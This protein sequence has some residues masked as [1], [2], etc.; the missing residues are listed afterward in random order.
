MQLVNGEKRY[1]HVNEL[2]DANN[3]EI[4][5]PHRTLYVGQE[6]KP[7]NLQ[8]LEKYQSGKLTDS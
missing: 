7:L 5:F 6:S 4:P 2:F 3:V 8:I 1:G